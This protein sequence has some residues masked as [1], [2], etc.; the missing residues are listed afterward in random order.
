MASL[1]KSPDAS[2]T[3]VAFLVLSVTILKS[4]QS[5]AFNQARD[6]TGKYPFDTN[7]AIMVS[8]VIKTCYHLT[9][10][11]FKCLKADKI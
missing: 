3:R 6:E 1:L 11:F 5:I 9:K 7:G 2:K 10:L 8:E 4:T